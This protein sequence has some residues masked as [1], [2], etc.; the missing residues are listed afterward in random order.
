MLRQHWA[1]RR[2]VSWRTYD[3]PF[4]LLLGQAAVVSAELDPPLEP[5]ESVGLLSL[6]SLFEQSV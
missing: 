5:H 6:P 1:A 3:A 2:V 4:T